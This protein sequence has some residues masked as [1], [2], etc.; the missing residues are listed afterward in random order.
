MAAPATR[1]IKR[2]VRALSQ[3]GIWG[4]RILGSS[5]GM[6]EGADISKEN[7]KTRP[8]EQ[9]RK[10]WVDIFYQITPRVV[11]GERIR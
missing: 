10:A 2:R 4:E 6:G 11:A 8:R 3:A 5:E 7:G 1:V 9:V